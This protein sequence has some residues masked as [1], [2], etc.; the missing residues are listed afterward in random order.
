MSVH[1]ENPKESTDKIFKKKMSLARYWIQ[2]QNATQQFYFYSLAT[3]N[4]IIF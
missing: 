4:Q 2:A 1:V 3:G